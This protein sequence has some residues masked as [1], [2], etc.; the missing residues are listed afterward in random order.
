MVWGYLVLAGIEEVI[1]V[2]AMKQIDGT[3]KKWPIL[4]VIVGFAFSFYC[5]SQAMQTLSAGVAYAVWTGVGSVGITIAGILWFKEK[6][7]FLQLLSLCFI[8]IGVAG[9]RMT[10]S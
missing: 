1:A 3:R 10:S 6:F 4:V 2:I 7:T 9:L 5:L 8:L